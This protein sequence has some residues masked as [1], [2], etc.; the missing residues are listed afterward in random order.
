MM[1][2]GPGTTTPSYMKGIVIENKSGSKAEVS[3]HFQSG[4]NQV[5]TIN[6]E[7]T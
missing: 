4:K 7:T 6:Q 3:V 1:C 2:G 5:Y